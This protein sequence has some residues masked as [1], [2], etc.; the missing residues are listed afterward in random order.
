M[1]PTKLPKMAITGAFDA[2]AAIKSKINKISLGLKIFLAV[3]VMSFA[4]TA[5]VIGNSTYI[6]YMHQI[7]LVDAAKKQAL[8]GEDSIVVDATAEIIMKEAIVKPPKEVAKQYAIWIYE[9]A[10]KNAVDPLMILSVMR[11]ES[12]FNYRALSPTGAIGLMQIIYSWHKEKTTK[13]DLFDPKNN[14]DVGAQ[15]IKEYS[16]RSKTDIEM[17]LRYNGT[18][19]QAPV[20]ATKV[21]LNQQR[22][23][24]EIFKSIVGN[25]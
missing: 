14:I 6:N 19:G 8:S 10:A 7:A 17:L 13:A 15:I 2:T 23:E 25:T 21:L 18:L 5:Y 3:I 12:Q 1:K 24:K 9:A 11:V 22:Y 20:Y 4:S 16:K